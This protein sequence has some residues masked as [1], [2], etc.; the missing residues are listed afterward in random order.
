MTTTSALTAAAASVIQSEVPSL[1]YPSPRRDD[2][3]RRQCL[4]FFI[5]GNP[6]LIGYYTPFLS[7]LRQLLDETEGRDG[8]GY[9]FHIYGRNLLGFDDRDH[10][11]AFGTTT[12]GGVRVE[13]YTLEDQIRALCEH[14][15]EVNR[16]ALR[17]AAAGGRGRAFDKVVLIGHSVGAYMVLEMFN[18]HHQARRRRGED[19]DAWQRTEGSAVL[20]SLA[21]VEL[22]AGILLFP[23]VSH[24]A[25]SSSG[26]KLDLIRQTPLLDRSAH[27]IAK[28]F[29][30]LWPRWVLDAIVRRLLGF[31]EHAAR[32]TVRFLTS[33]DGI[34][35]ALH[36]GKDE[37][38]TITEDKWSE[39]LWEIQEAEEKETGLGAK[40]FFYFAQKDHWVADECRDD[41][42]EKRRRHEKGKTRIVIDEEKIPHAF[43]IRES[44]PGPSESGRRWP[45]A[46]I[47]YA[48]IIARRWRKRSSLGLRTLRASSST[49]ELW[50]W[51]TTGKY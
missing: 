6:G 42:I 27:R 41:F 18:R 22:T 38:R 11:P 24:I 50:L 49:H 2:I 34:W 9:A 10:E 17:G 48:Q 51:H 23:T 13:P 29:A 12:A 45:R 28:A 25:R 14:V 35:Q 37:M 47:E 40:F 33:R 31:P 8:C 30:D 1:E 5:P 7:T 32:A 3:A 16:S 44:N 39:D 43:C 4:V 46:D 26:Q 15:G 21:S 20:D 36:M 19:G